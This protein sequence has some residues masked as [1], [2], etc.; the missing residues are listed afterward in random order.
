MCCKQAL[1]VTRGVSSLN[2]TL[3]APRLQQ[4]ALVSLPPRVTSH[5]AVQRCHSLSHTQLQRPRQIIGVTSWRR[6]VVISGVRRM[7]E[8]NARHV[9]L[10]LGW[11]IDRLRAGIPSRYVTSQLGQ[12]SLA[13][14]RSRRTS[15]G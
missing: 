4:T 1:R 12:L 15:F 13:S 14:L 9:R 8:V 11:V 7:N 6:G 10:V 2:A 5:N 3:H